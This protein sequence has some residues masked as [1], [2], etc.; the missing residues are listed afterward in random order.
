MTSGASG[1]TI[2]FSPKSYH[3]IEEAERHPER[4]RALTLH[5]SR[6]DDIE[7]RLSQ[8]RNLEDLTFGWCDFERFP[9]DVSTLRRLKKFTCLNTP[10][11]FL[12]DWLFEFPYLKCLTIRGTDI[13]AIPRA[14]CNARQ[15]ENIDFT[16]NDLRSV[17]NEIGTLRNLRHLCLG[18][19]PLEDLPPTMACLSQLRSL[20][21]V[22]T[23]FLEAEANTV[24]GWFHPG[25]VSVWPVPANW[26]ELDNQPQIV[27]AAELRNIR[28]RRAKA[29][30]ETEYSSKT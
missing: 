6:F 1:I 11:P 23:R 28:S 16:N 15:L 5:H 24:R 14:I 2:M 22:G 25:V 9:D 10:L 3:S 12:P 18:C 19:N 30:N 26:R 21:L 27:S 20:H 13:Q 7:G 8:F 29:E 4:V 17:P